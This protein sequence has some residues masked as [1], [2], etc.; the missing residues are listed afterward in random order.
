[1]SEKHLELKGIY[2]I[3]RV[4]DKTV[5][6]IIGGNETEEIKIRFTFRSIYDAQIRK[7]LRRIIPVKEKT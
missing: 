2:E 3:D 6:E 7:L 5:C 1:M 4:G